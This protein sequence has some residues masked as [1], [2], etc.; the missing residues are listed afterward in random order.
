RVGDPRPSE[1][2]VISG[3]PEGSVEVAA[4]APQQIRPLEAATDVILRPARNLV[5]PVV[6]E[7]GVLARAS[8]EQII[9]VEAADLVVSTQPV[10]D[11]D[12]SCAL[13]DVVSTGCGMLVGR[14]KR[15]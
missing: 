15:H 2:R 3:A 8:A 13:E 5:P 6:S 1:N 12:S 4:A 14:F 11:V 10:D 7:Q 9:S